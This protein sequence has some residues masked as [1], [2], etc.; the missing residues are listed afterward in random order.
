LQVA[1]NHAF[2]M[3]CLEGETDLLDDLDRFSWRQLAPA[4][5]KIGQ[6]LTIDELHG[7]ELH[8]IRFAKVV[9]ADH[10]AMRDL[11]GQH[12]FLFEKLNDARIACQIGTDYLQRDYAFDVAV[13]RLVNRA[14]S[15]QSEHL[16]DLIATAKD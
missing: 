13:V 14:H 5:E 11:P 12:E 1:M 3:R 15:A 8:P 16:L 2:S 7:D 4:L 9:N 6:R 10:V